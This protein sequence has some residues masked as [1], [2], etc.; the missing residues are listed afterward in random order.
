MSIILQLRILYPIWVLLGVFGIMYV[1]STIIEFT[2]PI[3]TIENITENTFLYRLGIG[4][5]L[6][7]QLF[8]IVIPFLLYKL[9]KKLDNTVSTLMLILALIS[10]PIT[11]LNESI[12]SNVINHLD[13]PEK[14]IDMLNLYNQVIHISTIFWGLWLLPLG[15]LVYKFDLFPKFIGVCLFIGGF[16]Y[17]INSFKKIIL[18]GFNQLDII[19]DIMTFGELIFILWFVMR[20]IKNERTTTCISNKG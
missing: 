7:T 4:A 19:W 2:D 20:G 12:S 6:I 5:R 9:F 1:P 11:M 8:F 16:G 15:W 17:L 10:V 3:K 18:P 14:V 13:N